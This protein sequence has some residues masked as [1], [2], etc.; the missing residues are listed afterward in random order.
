MKTAWEDKMFSKKWFFDLE[1]KL[2]EM[3]LDSDEQSFDEIL[4]NL[5]HPKRVS[6]NQFAETVSYVILA[7]GFNQ[8]T[9]KIKHR[10]IMDLLKNNS[11]KSEILPVFKNESKIDAIITVWNNRQS[12]CDGFYKCQNLEEKIKYLLQ[13]SY[14]GETTV[15]HLARNLGENL[16]KYDRWIKRLGVVFSGNKSL[17][18]S[19]DKPKL[20]PELKQAC[21]AMFNHLV[22]ET[23]LPIGY[24]DVV[25]FRA[26]QNHLIDMGDK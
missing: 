19:L 14:V 18:E 21:D 4:E 7:S 12:L 2:R 16:P 17:N 3:G 1:S 22:Q 8:K 9:A 11:N 25:L 13:I 24:I 23:G 26:C 15:N 10:I 5:K 20:K 6:P